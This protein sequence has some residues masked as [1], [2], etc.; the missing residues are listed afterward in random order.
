MAVQA[1]NPSSYFHWLRCSCFLC[2]PFYY[3]SHVLYLASYFPF[4]ISLHQ[5]VFLILLFFDYFYFLFSFYLSLC[6]FTFPFSPPRFLFFCFCLLSL[7]SSLSLP[8][9]LF[10]HF[11]LCLFCLVLHFFYFYRI[12]L[13]SSPHLSLI[14]LSFLISLSLI[15][16]P[17]PPAPPHT[18]RAPT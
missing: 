6:I 5:S 9:F 14:F 18:F 2:E 7:D 8:P 15:L 16:L 1:G 13:Y 12:P 3:C 4:F 17:Q 10:S 11:S